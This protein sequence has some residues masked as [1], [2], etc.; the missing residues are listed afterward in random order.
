M[1]ALVNSPKFKGFEFLAKTE[2]RFTQVTCNVAA[3]SK[4]KLSFNDSR[5]LLTDSLAS[6][7]KAWIS[8]GVDDPKLASLLKLFYP[9]VSEE[10]I[11]TLVGI[12]VK[13]LSSLLSPQR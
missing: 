8:P 6:L 5:M 13:R 1:D 11:N 4:V 10:G 3:N 2:S 7:A 12:S 9:K